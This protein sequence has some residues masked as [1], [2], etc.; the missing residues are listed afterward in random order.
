MITVAKGVFAPGH[1][2][3]L[4]RIVPFEMVDAVLAETGRTQQRVRLLPARVVVYL[5]LA[6][7][8]F[9]EV[10]YLGVW[11]KLV[12]GLHGMGLTRPSATGLWHAR[13]RV[14]VAP[15][16]ALFDLLRGP[17]A[18]IRTVGV[19][20]CGL[21]VTAIDGTVFDVPDSPGHTVRLGKN[22]SQHGTAGYP[23]VRLVAL[24]ACGTRAVIDA[25][26]GP[27]TDGETTHAARLLRSL[28]PRM[29]VLLDRGF[30]SNTFLGAVAGTGAQFLVR[31]NGNRKPPVLARHHDGSY[32][33]V[34]G[35]V[36]VRII[37][38]EITVSTTAGTRTGVY[39]LATTLL[40]HRRFPA[41]EIVKL[42]HQRWEVESAY[43]EIKSTLLGRRVLR[44]PI[45]ALITQEIYALL[46]IYQVLRIAITDT[47]DAAGGVDPDRASF[48]TAVQTAKDLIVQAANVIAETTIDLIGTIGRH[49]LD[50]LMPTRR[51]RVSPR[52]VKRPLSRYAYK[53]LGVD[54]KSYL[55]TLS[56]DIIAGQPA[57]TDQ[58]DP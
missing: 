8:L 14:G 15:L 17:A 18:S 40:D 10:G 35:G 25:V 13:V 22:R 39:R 42:Y 47:T 54:R 2:G 52:T 20:W 44:S 46:T 12:A 50:N 6:A 48:T 24:V 21:L 38:C 55:A 1:L 45:P 27:R 9:A 5:L 58:G 26:F 41:F 57:L 56:I 34:I 36:R 37:A 31:L 3:E 16:R 32:T 51:L 19:W 23:Q 43:L 33:S 7:G 49:L 11:D 4:T 53:S 30:D 28:H 29:I